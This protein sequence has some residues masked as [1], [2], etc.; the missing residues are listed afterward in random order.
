[1]GTAG[2]PTGGRR[3]RL[4]DAATV[5]PNRGSHDTTDMPAIPPLEPPTATVIVRRLIDPA[6]TVRSVRR[7][8]GGSINRVLA[9]QTDGT[10]ATIVAKTND[11]THA[12]TLR[13]EHD[14]L[15]HLGA[16]TRLPV[17]APYGIMSPGD[18]GYPGVCLLMEW[19]PG[20]VMTEARVSHRG[21][22]HL[23]HRLAEHVAELHTHTRSEF[24]AAVGPD[25]A[26][27][28]TW[29][30]VF[31]PMIRGEFEKVREQLSSPTRRLIDDLVHHLGRW[32]PERATPTLVHG[33]LWGNN[34]MVDDRHPD[35]PEITAFIDGSAAYADPEYEL[36]YLR[37]FNTADRRFFDAYQRRHRIREG[38][39]RRARVYWLNTMMLHVRTFGEKYVP[40]VEKI[41]GELKGMR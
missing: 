1:M 20:K 35:R 5:L 13:R 17:P 25:G 22:A 28:A 11:A 3:S 2:R 29:L 27:Q 8:H 21:V 10:P 15:A 24:G 26:G 31:E 40:S 4:Y 41:A 30:G 16:I 32:L 36:A 12:G 33:D 23:Q 6:L 38:F 39:D 37:V 9:L 7:M 34:I 19:M 18:E 14:A